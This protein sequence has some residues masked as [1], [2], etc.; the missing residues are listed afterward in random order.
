MRQTSTKQSSARSS[1][2]RSGIPFGLPLSVICLL[3]VFLVQILAL[4]ESASAHAG[5]E[6]LVINQPAGPFFVSV[7]ALP[8][9]LVIGEANFIVFV[10]EE[11]SS[12]GNR[13]NT[14]VLNA[15]LSLELAAVDTDQSVRL[16]PS[17]AI[18]TNKL[19]YE[20]YVDIDEANNY[21]ATLEISFE[22]RRG[23]ITFPINVDAAPIEINWFLYSSLAA[24]IL[25]VG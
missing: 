19:F 12:G 24:I 18:S 8:K 2:R 9:P 20:S 4:P 7:W 6:P 3:L 10:A 15:D 23:E 25:S 5:G 11:V 14:P 22:G 21:M 1:V 13:A 17:H 16:T